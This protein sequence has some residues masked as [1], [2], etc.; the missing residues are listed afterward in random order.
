M[1]DCIRFKERLH[2]WVDGELG[3]VVAD[4]VD[5]HLS[6]CPKCA[7]AARAIEHMKLL[8][9]SKVRQS[10]VPE[11][12]AGKVR[13]AITIESARYSH[14]KRWTGRRLV[15]FAT[16]AAILLVI[17]SSINPFSSTQHQE[18]Q[19]SV[20]DYVFDSH[21]RSV[22]GDDGPEWF[23]EGTADASTRISQELG[24]AVVLP[25]PDAML[26]GVS[27]SSLGETRIAKVFYMLDSEPLSIFII[28]R[29]DGVMDGCH[30][31]KKGRNF[32]VFCLPGESVCYL[33]A[34][35]Q[36]AK[37]CQQWFQLGCCGEPV[38]SD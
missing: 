19:A 27:F 5:T 1:E 6:L 34:T 29:P 8:V 38:T 37:A 17:L 15:P 3:E 30:C 10:R 31:I 13:Q 18:L 2:E 12:L 20:G 32:A 35:S 23:F 22:T 36:D 21:L 25:A 28:P 33:F 24:V 7:D 11:G 26:Q 16:A 9:K 14:R 4:E